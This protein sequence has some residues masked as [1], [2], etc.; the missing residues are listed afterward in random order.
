MMCI[1]IRILCDSMQA[2]TFGDSKL[3]VQVHHLEPNQIK[4]N[5][6]KLNQTKNLKVPLKKLEGISQSRNVRS[7]H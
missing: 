1:F 2:Q 5:Q 6:A 3:K 4:P 7:L